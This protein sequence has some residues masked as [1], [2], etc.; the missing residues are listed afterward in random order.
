MVLTQI[1]S[2]V[3]FSKVSE[4]LVSDAFNIKLRFFF[5]TLHQSVAVDSIRFDMI[6]IPGAWINV[7]PTVEDWTDP[8][9]QPRQTLRFSSTSA[10]RVSIKS[11]SLKIR[12]IRDLWSVSFVLTLLSKTL[13]LFRYSAAIHDGRFPS[14]RYLESGSSQPATAQNW[15][16][17]EAITADGGL[18][19]SMNSCG[20]LGWRQQI[21]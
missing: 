13:F 6:P 18:V 15:R 1:F 7:N 4:F 14:I 12:G 2:D 21:I 5:G 20:F 9:S 10:K 17:P 16:I 11:L 19:E 3:W 8:R